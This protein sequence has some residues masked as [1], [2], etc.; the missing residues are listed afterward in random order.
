MGVYVC[1]CVCV[2]VCV[3]VCVWVCV[4]V[5]VCL[6][7][8]VFGVEVFECVDFTRLGLNFIKYD[9]CW[10]MR[11]STTFVLLGHDTFYL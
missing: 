10:V 8:W 3:S 5:F 11:H 9:I 4:C 6:G 2:C 7:V 1:V